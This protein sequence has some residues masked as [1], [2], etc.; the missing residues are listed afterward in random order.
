MEVK[1]TIKEEQMYTEQEIEQGFLKWN[2]EERLTPS[3]FDTKE[4]MRCMDVADL[5]IAN[6]ETLINYIKQ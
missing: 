1:E 4:E 2:T 5:S 6:A 3:K